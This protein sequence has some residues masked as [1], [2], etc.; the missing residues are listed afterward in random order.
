MTSFSGLSNLTSSNPPRPIPPVPPNFA[1]CH[2]GYGTGFSRT[3]ALFAASRLPS[4]ATP[5]QYTID[6]GSPPPGREGFFQLP[7]EVSHDGVSVSVEVCSPVNLDSIML[8]PDDLRG[9]AGF[10]ALSCVGTRHTGGWITRGIQGVINYVTDPSVNLDTDLYPPDTAFITVTMSPPGL[11]YSAPGDYD[12][13]MAVFLQQ[14]ITDVLGHSN[15]MN[16]SPMEHMELA[17]RLIR[18]GIQAQNMRRLGNVAWWDLP[19]SLSMNASGTSPALG[20]GQGNGSASTN[21]ATSRRK[22]RHKSRPDL[23]G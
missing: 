12:P 3:Q 8:R 20:K 15:P 11:A 4:G 19:D 7:L 6:P 21:T 22:K 5:V 17:D 1:F 10:L 2:H 14:Q 18:L 23:W 13:F 9:M 16:L